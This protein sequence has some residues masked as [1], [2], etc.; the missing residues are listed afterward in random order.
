MSALPPEAYFP[1]PLVISAKVPIPDISGLSGFSAT[2]IARLA[3]F[4]L[5]QHW[6]HARAP[7]VY[8]P[9]KL[10][11]L[12]H[13]EPRTRTEVLRINDGFRG[14]LQRSPVVGDFNS[15]VRVYDPH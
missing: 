1:E 14:R 8:L 10:L 2:A 3:M 9:E 13:Q 7:V 15:F 5:P 4:V 6:S 12:P 11:R